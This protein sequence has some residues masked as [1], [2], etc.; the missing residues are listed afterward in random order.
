MIALTN[1]VLTSC[2]LKSNFL[3]KQEARKFSAAFVSNPDFHPLKGNTFAWYSDLYVDDAL[4]DI[5]ISV[6]ARNTI[7]SY[8]ADSIQDQK[9]QFLVDNQH[10]DYLVSAMVVLGDKSIQKAAPFFRAYP[11]IA[12]SINQYKKG[13]LL[14][15]VSEHKGSSAKLMWQGAIQVY[16]VGDD[17][18]DEERSRRLK[19]MVGRLIE[20]LPDAL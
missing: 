14:V 8:I 11:Q 17:L 18:S 10:A 2:S 3:A 7:A 13:S 15:I 20:G 12:E 16:I 9:F 4:S 19:G 1:I 5:K 6:Q